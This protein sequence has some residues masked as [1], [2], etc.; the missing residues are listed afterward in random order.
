[1]GLRSVRVLFDEAMVVGCGSTLNSRISSFTDGNCSSMRVRSGV[2]CSLPV[3]RA[4]AQRGGV[5]GA[6]ESRVR[7]KS[8]GVKGEE[9]RSEG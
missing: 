4:E 8:S 3:G 5:V 7:V 9:R 2:S 6:A 1:M